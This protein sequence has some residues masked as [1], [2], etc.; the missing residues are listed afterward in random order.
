MKVFVLGGTGSI[1]TPL[2]PAF[3]NRGHDVTSLARSDESEAILREKGSSVLRGDIRDPA[4]WSAEAV[5]ADVIVQ[6]AGTF[7]EDENAV[8]K[9]IL[10]ALVQASANSTTPPKLLYTGG[11]WLY[12]ETEDRVAHEEDGYRS[13][14]AF[15]WVIDNYQYA[16]STE[17]LEIVMLHPAMVYSEEGGVLDRFIESARDKGQVEVWGAL[18]TRWPVVHSRDLAEAY[19]LAAEQG[20]HGDV[21]N[22]AAEYGVSVSDMVDAVSRKFGLTK[23][24]VTRSAEELVA[25]YGSWAVGPTIDQQMGADRIKSKLG[26]APDETDVLNFIA[27]SDWL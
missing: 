27:R 23:Q 21:F 3:V 5:Q 6:V 1:G 20:R 25:A 7:T 16:M 2:V 18:N 8:D 26:W 22:V 10:E 24:P 12:G 4:E 13:I 14:D 9:G 17:S 11:C 15:S 19:L